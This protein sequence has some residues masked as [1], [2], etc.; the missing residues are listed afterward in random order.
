MRLL[1]I[2]DLHL[3]KRLNEHDLYED[4]AYLL[5]QI[6][7][8]VSENQV[9]ALLIAG[10]IFD[11]SIPSIGAVELLDGFLTELSALLVPVFAISGNHDSPERLGFLKGFLKKSGIYL[12]TE[13]EGGLEPVILSDEYGEAAIYSLPFVKPSMLTAYLT[14]EER[15]SYDSAVHAIL[16]RESPD[17]SRRN[18]L[19]AHQFVTGAGVELIRSESE[20]V[21]V[22]GVDNVDVSAFADFDYTALGHIHREQQVGT[23]RVRYS[24]AP[25]PYSLS[26]ADSVKGG[27]LVELKEKGTLHCEKIV[28]RPLHAVRV[29]KGR[30]KELL[31]PEY[32]EQPLD[33]IHMILTDEERIADAASMVKAVYPNLLRL[34][35]DTGRKKAAGLPEYTGGEIA[36]KT[37]EE[38]FLTFFQAMNQS[39]PS[40]EQAGLMREIFEEE[41]QEGS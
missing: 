29:L 34:E 38:L 33:Y 13:Y 4:Q 12:T 1:H 14:E 19:V 15:A 24:G 32:V 37:P 39:V 27:I 10:D 25:Y 5:K 7:K 40:A 3:G 17:P 6:I 2:S 41:G 8:A 28:F 22:G 36:R 21:N 9:D 26:E 20:S 35:Y 30:L 18:I 31:K 11:R 23:E 16:K